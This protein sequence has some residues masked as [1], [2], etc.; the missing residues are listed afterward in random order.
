M[1]IQWFPGHMHKAK[2]E[3]EAALPKIDVVLEIL[4]ARCPYSSSNPLLDEIVGDKPRL[5]ILSKSDLADPIL[6]QTWLTFFA[7][8]TSHRAWAITT[9]DIPSIRNIKSLARQIAANREGKDVRCMVVGIPNVGK[10]TIINHLANR[11]IAKTGNAPAITQRQ[12]RIPIGDGVTLLD[13]PGVMW[14]NV[15]NPKCG[16]RLA[17]IGSIRETALDF[18]EVGFF[19]AEL[20]AN[21]MPEALQARYK[22]DALP[23]TTLGLVESIGAKR[24]CLGKNAVVDLDRA[25][26][27]LV[28][29]FRNGA[30]GKVTL[31]TPDSMLVEIEETR[32][33]TH[34]RLEKKAEKTAERKR[35]F[36]KRNNQSQ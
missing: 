21:T 28:N 17:L 20:L 3:I 6:I 23:E 19:T 18:A 8:N 32:R 36:R 33:L 1:T 29:D 14:P 34:E 35:R 22:L 31:E 9:E 26:R 10:S 16:Y 15:D 11:K 2:T 7:E 12:Q 27:I 5:K 30:F 24:G 25:S 4:D 13:T